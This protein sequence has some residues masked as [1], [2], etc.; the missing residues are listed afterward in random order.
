MKAP[1]LSNQVPRRRTPA[2]TVSELEKLGYKNFS[3]PQ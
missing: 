3:V 1:L 2:L